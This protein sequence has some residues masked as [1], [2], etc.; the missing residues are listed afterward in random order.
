MGAACSRR[1]AHLIIHNLPKR[2]FYLED[3]FD[4]N[5]IVNRNLHTYRAARMATGFAKDF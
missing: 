5:G 3:H 2:S 1:H 4:L